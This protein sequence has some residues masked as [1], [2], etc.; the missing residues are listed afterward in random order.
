[1]KRNFTFDQL[2]LA[3]AMLTE[4]VNELKR[5][6]IEQRTGLPTEHTEKL[7]NVKEAAKFLN[8][9]VPTVYSKVSKGELP[10]M[11]RG[12]HL[13]FSSTELMDYVKAGRRKTNSELEQEAERYFSKKK[14]LGYEK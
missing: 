1:M 14:G 9:T 8:L 2:P 10:H 4:E 7:L 6:L 11:K 12:K 3:V 13:H 5:L